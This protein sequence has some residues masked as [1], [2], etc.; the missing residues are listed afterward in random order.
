[1]KKI[2]A[3]GICLY[4]TFNGRHVEILLCKSVQS[5]TKWGLL[6]GV[7]E[8]GETDIQTAIREFSEESSIQIDKSDLGKYF[9]QQNKSKDI[10]IWLVNADTIHIYNNFFINNYLIEEY[11]SSENSQVKFFNINKLPMIKNKQK[12]LIEQ[13]KEYFKFK[14]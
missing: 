7:Q 11:V 12:Y 8:N 9:E 10:G 6:K 3:F 14:V 5:K 13:I 1:M 2:K 4:K